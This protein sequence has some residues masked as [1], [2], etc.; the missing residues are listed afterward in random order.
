MLKTGRHPVLQTQVS[1]H[2][3]VIKLS[4]LSC[5]RELPPILNLQLNRFQFDMQLGR[6]RKLNS[7]IQ[8]PEEL[9]MIEYLGPEAKNTKY[10][11]TGVL[12]HLGP[13]ANHGHYI[14]NIQDMET[15]HWF[16]FSDETVNV[17]QGKML[18][19]GNDDELAG[20]GI[21]KQGVK[22]V[23]GAGK[24]GDKVQTSNNAYM[25]VYM[26]RQT[27]LDIRAH[28]IRERTKKN[29]IR[30]AVLKKQNVN[31]SEYCLSNGKIFPVNFPPHL[32]TKIEKDNMEFEEERE[33][34]L[35][36]REHE[37]IETRVK[38]RRM[39][40]RYRSLHYDEVNGPNSFEFLPLAWITKWLMNPSTCGPIDTRPLLCQHDRLDIDKLSDV[41][42][43][44]TETVSQLRDDDDD[45][46]DVV[47]YDGDDDDDVDDCY[48]DKDNDDD[49]VAGEPAP[50]GAR[51]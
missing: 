51:G 27:L 1:C 50:G 8:F 5:Y 7:A 3:A 41:K 20:P 26:E 15:G 37:R 35:S 2:Q 25:L 22:V 40:E 16:R 19:L 45:D 42:I 10:S 34:R 31:L 9:D 17:L 39:V 12:M 47:D 30:T 28:E 23:K 38:Q 14:A 11:L 46:N 44:D 33:E 36:S 29:L 4:Q 48:D 18:K 49:D 6:K 21:K 32:K 24:P 13:D 43:C